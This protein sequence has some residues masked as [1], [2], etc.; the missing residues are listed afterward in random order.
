MYKDVWIRQK[1]LAE[2][3][4]V[5]PL[6]KFAFNLVPTSPDLRHFSLLVPYPFFFSV[7]F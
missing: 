7:S 4:T 5:F 2:V 6:T 1:F 3:I